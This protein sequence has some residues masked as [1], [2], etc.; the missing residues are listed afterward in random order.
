MR[1]QFFAAFA[2]KPR[3]HWRR[4]LLR[5]RAGFAQKFDGL[6]QPRVERGEFGV[7]GDERLQGG[8]FVR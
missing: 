3:G 4:G 6:A 5:D 8:S 7:C 2:G 1:E